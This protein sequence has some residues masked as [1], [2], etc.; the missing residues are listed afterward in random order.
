VRIT[1]KLLICQQRVL[2]AIEEFQDDNMQDCKAFGWSHLLLS[3]VNF[4]LES[5]GCGSVG[6]LASERFVLAR[7]MCTRRAFNSH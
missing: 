4:E 6:N 1:F 5:G 7:W 2:S 3:G